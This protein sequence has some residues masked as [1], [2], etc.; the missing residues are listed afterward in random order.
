MKVLSI[1]P[2]RSGSKGIPN[3]N[4]IKIKNINLINYTINFSKKHRLIDYTFVST[5]SPKIKKIS[6]KT[7]LSIP[8][9]RP[10]YLSGDKSDIYNTIVYTLNKLELLQKIRYDV[11]LLLQPTSP[12][13]VKSDLDSALRLIRNQ[14]FDSVIS[15]SKYKGISPNVMYKL[16]KN[17]LEPIKKNNYFQ[18]QQYE[19]IYFRNGLIYAIKRRTLLEKKSIYGTSVGFIEIPISRSINLDTKI[20]LQILK[21][22]LGEFD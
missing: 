2:A 3:K 5:D 10:K 9:L 19:N 21:K 15:I 17:K 4:I 8:F 6:E 22:K 11:I 14:K 16:N 18:R 12:L 1:I 20:D 13:R 7:G